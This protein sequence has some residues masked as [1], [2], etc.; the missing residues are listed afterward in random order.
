MINSW[1]VE[2]THPRPIC[3]FPLCFFW[4][5]VFLLLI[6]LDA[7]LSEF[8]EANPLVFWPIQRTTYIRGRGTTLH[9]VGL[10][11]RGRPHAP[12]WFQSYRDEG[13]YFFFPL[14]SSLSFF[15]FISHSHLLKAWPLLGV[16]GLDY[17]RLASP[18]ANLGH[19]DLGCPAGCPL[20]LSARDRMSSKR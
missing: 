10:P 14:V 8:D 13:L 5:L 9:L 4:D 3:K 15:V 17:E 19:S 7:N 11:W 2:S 6:C 1:L 12:C 16:S 18:R 20:P